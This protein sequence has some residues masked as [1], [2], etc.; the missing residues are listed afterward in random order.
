MGMDLFPL[1]NSVLESGARRSP[2]PIRAGELRSHSA[3]YEPNPAYGPQRS[4][5]ENRRRSPLVGQEVLGQSIRMVGQFL[6]LHQRDS[7][8]MAS[9]VTF[10]LEEQA[11]SAV[12]EEQLRHEYAIA[13][14]EFRKELSAENQFA[15]IT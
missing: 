5:R 11:A 13:A 6:H 2:R 9:R 8:Q 4:A 1:G 7:E 10:E 15:Q 3:G 12:R 14:D